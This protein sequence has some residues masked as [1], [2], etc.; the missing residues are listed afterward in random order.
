MLDTPKI[1]I[2][3]FI[4]IRNSSTTLIASSND[5]LVKSKNHLDNPQAFAP[6]TKI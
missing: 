4:S 6:S 3:F 5:K 2:I 1:S